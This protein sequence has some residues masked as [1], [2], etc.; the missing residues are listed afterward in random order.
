MGDLIAQGTATGLSGTWVMG[1]Y[2][3]L[4]AVMGLVPHTHTPPGK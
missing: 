3:A 1:K 2:S 4:L